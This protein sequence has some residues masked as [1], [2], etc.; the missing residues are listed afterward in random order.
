MNEQLERIEEKL[1][2]IIGVLKENPEYE[3]F[4]KKAL[5]NNEI[6][7]SKKCFNERKVEWTDMLLKFAY[8]TIQ[9]KSLENEI[10]QIKLKYE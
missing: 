8:S 7:K 1:D 3:S 6:E 9:S 10:T 4:V 2:L 5:M